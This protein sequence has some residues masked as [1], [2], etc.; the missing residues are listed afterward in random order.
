[1]K[2]WLAALL[3]KRE[4]GGPRVLLYHRVF[5]PGIDPQLLCVSPENFRSQMQWLKTRC[6]VVSL[7]D[8]V[9]QAGLGLPP[10]SVSVT[11][12]DGYFDNLLFAKPILEESGIQATVFVS[13][14][15]VD[16]KREMWWD[17]AEQIFLSG[18]Q[19]A[20]DVTRPADTPE[21]VEYLDACR[22]LK[23]MAP[24]ERTATI[25]RMASERGVQLTVRDSHRGLSRSEL[26][27]LAAGKFVDIGGHTVNHPALSHLGADEQRRE[28]SA[29][30]SAL[31]AIT[32]KPIS[33]FAYPFGT[34]SEFDSTTVSCVGAAGY[35]IACANIPAPIKADVERLAVPRVLI[36]N[37][38][39]EVF[40]ERMRSWLAS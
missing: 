14:G 15:F 33:A 25:D 20:W 18:S 5:S 11:F 29:D 34:E 31:Q 8:M 17:E 22:K 26:S 16:C 3:G 9:A 4:P 19:A 35:D 1:M 12:D 21:K 6:N 32:G 39:A 37:W 38:S 2:S 27:E 23:F 13:S 7:S 40:G 30:R 10:D 36:R 24:A 28:I